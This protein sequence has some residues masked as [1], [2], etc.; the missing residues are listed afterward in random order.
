MRY[1]L[2]AASQNFRS[3][4]SEAGLECSEPDFSIN[5]LALKT[6]SS[7][8]MLKC[9]AH[10]SYTVTKWIL[11]LFQE[12]INVGHSDEECD[13]LAYTLWGFNRWIEV[14]HSVASRNTV[15]MTQAEGDSLAEARDV[16]LS[17]YKA[18]SQLA[19]RDSL[20]A[21]QMIPK[22]HM[23][24]HCLRR[25]IDS[26]I[27]FSC[28]WVYSQESFMGR[29][30]RVSKAVHASVIASRAVDRWL[31]SYKAKTLGTAWLQLS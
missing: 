19:R 10:N 11:A 1:Q 26:H 15:I 6:L 4:L 13:L 28:F 22:Y 27:S 14:Q 29:S 17:G 5:R 31:S 18:L 30:A 25:S 8:P 2:D 16:G 7:M 12:K 3:F 24:D 9:K 21:Y 20:R 23:L